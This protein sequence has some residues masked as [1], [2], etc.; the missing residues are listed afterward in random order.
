[1]Q[2]SESCLLLVQVAKLFLV[3]SQTFVHGDE[4]QN[5]LQKLV[6]RYAKLP[7][8]VLDGGIFSFAGH[9]PDDG[10]IPDDP[11]VEQVLSVLEVGEAGIPASQL[12]PELRKMLQAKE[13]ARPDRHES[14]F[15]NL[16]HVTFT[17]NVAVKKG[18]FY[19]FPKNSI[20]EGEQ[21]KEM[22]F[23]YRDC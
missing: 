17:R 13:E 8:E 10:S 21:E 5:D 22:R 7:Q 23:E 3:P 6:D 11:V 12:D 9:P 4:L 18:I 20:A 15:E 2:N 1:M 19:R 14:S 16:N